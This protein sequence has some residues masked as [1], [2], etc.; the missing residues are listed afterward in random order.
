MGDHFVLVPARSLSCVR[1]FCHPMDCRLPGPSVRG[2]SQAR[3]LEWVDISF[4]RGSSPG[5]KPTSLASPA[6]AG[7]FFTTSL[8]KIY[9]WGLLGGPVVKTVCS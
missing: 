7:G 9:F 1:L 8:I 3:T 6:L 4:S 2:I 5:I